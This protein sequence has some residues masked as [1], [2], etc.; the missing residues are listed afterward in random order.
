[1]NAA[2]K[3]FEA[4]KLHLVQNAHFTAIQDKESVSLEELVEYLIESLE[5]ADTAQSSRAENLLVRIGKPAIPHLL[6]GLKS[7]HN[8]VKSVC[9]MALIRMGEWVVEDIKEFYVR[10]ASRTK[11]RWVA[12]FILTELSE[13]IPAIDVEECE[14]LQTRK[15]VEL[16]KVS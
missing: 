3:S 2:L 6:T 16:S 13:P 8:N 4:I 15:L 5:E 14:L 9:A 10:N 1:M 12:E 7:S 11:I